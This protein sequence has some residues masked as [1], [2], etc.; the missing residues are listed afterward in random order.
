MKTILIITR[1]P[2]I[3]FRQM[4]NADGTTTDGRYRF[5]INDYDAEAD[6]V[7]VSGKGLREPHTFHVAPR[8]TILLTGEPYGILAYPHGYCH[9][10]GLVCSC[11]PQIKD[12]NVVYTPAIL[13]WYVG[14]DFN[15]DGTVR[16]TKDYNGIANAKPKKTKLISV[17]SSTKAF[18]RG[19]VDRLRFIRKL[20]DCYGDAIDI[21]GR[22]YRDF[23]D[24]WD[25]LAPYKYH[26]VIENSTSDFYFTE[27]LFDCYLAG[28]YPLYHGC[29]N[30]TDYYPADAMTRID[31]RN[32]DETAATIDRIMT[33]NEFEEKQK[34]LEQCK[35]LSLNKYNLF[36]EIA[37]TCDKLD[38]DGQKTDVLLKPA[39]N[40]VSLHN[41][42]LY[43]F[44][45]NYYKLLSK[46]GNK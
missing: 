11:Q 30:I 17:I 44:G 37:R 20:H 25:V 9:Q 18:S 34:L 21:F 32:F 19:H 13:P 5:V 15:S 12:A 1:D 36:N 35:Q 22:G 14:V 2:V 7:V 24:K 3:N 46:I 39:S 38:A 33:S 6:F 4:P 16:F 43:T 41:L 27:K 23:A 8:N 42:W 26:I 31:I 40:F 29:R 45:R 28:T 10:F